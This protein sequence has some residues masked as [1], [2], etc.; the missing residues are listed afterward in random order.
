LEI[1]GSAG[2]VYPGCCLGSTKALLPL[3]AD[4]SPYAD[5]VMLGQNMAVKAYLEAKYHED[6]GNREEIEM[7]SNVLKRNGIDA[8]CIDRDLEHW[9]NRQ[10]PSTELMEKTF[11]E[12]DHSHVVILEMSKKGVGLGIEAGYGRA[13]GKPIVVLIKGGKELSK[14]MQGIASL[15]ISYRRIEEIG[16]MM[17]KHLPWLIAENAGS[18]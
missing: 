7:L 4:V 5:I 10:L 6:N 17:H 18:R 16:F 1:Y 8:L 11:Y 12:I 2:S 9:G 13:E 14:T 15:V 3:I